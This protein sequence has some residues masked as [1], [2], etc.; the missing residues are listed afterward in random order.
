MFETMDSWCQLKESLIDFAKPSLD[1]SVWIQGRDGSFKL[2]PTAEKAI[3][4]HLGKHPDANLLATTEKPHILGSLTTNQYLDDTDVDIHLFPK[5][6]AE[7]DEDKVRAVKAW[8][9]LPENTLYIGKHPVEVY[10]QVKPATDYL[11]PGFYDIETRKWE[12]G[13]K[14]VPSDYDPYEDFADIADDLRSSVKDAD[15][16]FGEIRRDIIDIETIQDA[17]SRM[18]PEDKA[19]FLEK[20]EVKFAEIQ[21]DISTLVDIKKGWVN[22]RRVTEPA[23]PEEALK[24]IE[25]AKEWRDSNALFKLIGRYQYITI[26]KALKAVVADDGEVTAGELDTIKKIVGGSDVPRST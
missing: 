12:K 11:S 16:L 14:I 7:W 10:V 19:I 22:A 9:E 25:L 21:D 26:I 2:Q 20:L 18:S 24:D 15:L 13:P 8:Y 23:S 1:S 17:I 3:L 5:N 4:D 6:P